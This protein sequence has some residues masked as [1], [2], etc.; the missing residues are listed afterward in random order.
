[1]R[2]SGNAVVQLTGDNWDV[3][4]SVHGWR[5]DRYREVWP[6]H[7]VRVWEFGPLMVE[8]QSSYPNDLRRSP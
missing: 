5:R 2:L 4:L 7:E 1:M 3:S 8:V 6:T